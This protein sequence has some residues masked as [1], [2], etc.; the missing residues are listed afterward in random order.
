MGFLIA[1]IYI[2]ILFLL[3]VRIKEEEELANMFDLPVLGQIPVFL[4]EGVKTHGAYGKNGYTHEEKG[5]NE[6]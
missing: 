4:P 3:D 5:G 2:T 6:R 1:A